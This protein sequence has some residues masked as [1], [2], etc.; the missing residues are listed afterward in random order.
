MRTICVLGSTGSIGT[1]ALDVIRR[2]PDLFRV[3]GLAAATSKDLLVGQIREFTPPLVAIADEEAANEL[4]TKLGSLRGVEIMS[5]PQAAETLARESEADMVLNALVGAVGLSPSLAALQ[6]GKMLALANKESL[7]IGGELIMDLV[8]GEPD[9]LVPVDSEHSALSQCLRGERRDDLKR[10]LITASGGPFRGW[11]RSELEK[12]SVKEAL[13]HPTWNM[14]PKITIDSATLM[15]KGLE[16][17]EA[18]YLFGLDYRAIDVVVHPESIIHGLAEFAD[19]SVIAQMATPDMRLPIQLALAYP[20]RLSVGIERLD[21]PKLGRLSFEELDRE[22]FPAVDLAYRAGEMGLTYPAALNA[23]NE[24]AV[25][26]FL[27]GKIR[28]TQIAEVIQAVLEEHEAAGVVSEVT[29][30]RADAWA[31]SRAAELVESP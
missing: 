12:A 15:N 26:G 27:E 1:Q 18:H 28:L 2:N 25:M 24:V 30:S 21:L 20:E 11:T 8:K 22:A 23:A 5:G 6:S 9:R 4:K 7:V 3:A 10:V 19:G 31:R 29:L 16:V 17:I 13:A 14:G